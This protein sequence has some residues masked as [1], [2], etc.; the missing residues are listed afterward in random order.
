MIWYETDHWN[1]YPFEPSMKMMWIGS[2]RKRR[3]CDRNLLHAIEKRWRRWRST[4]TEKKSNYMYVVRI[5]YYLVSPS[6]PAVDHEP[7]NLSFIHSIY[8]SCSTTWKYSI[9]ETRLTFRHIFTNKRWSINRTNRKNSSRILHF[10]GLLFLV[11][12]S[13]VLEGT[14]VLVVEATGADGVCLVASEGILVVLV[15]LVLLVL[16]VWLFWIK[17]SLSMA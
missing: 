14:L 8:T 12:G 15:V 1:I 17:G 6:R 4:W 3:I 11:F 9:N 5:D 16:L 13:G 2:S 7:K 10:L